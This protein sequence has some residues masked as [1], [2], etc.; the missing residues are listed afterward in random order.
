MFRDRVEAGRRLAQ[1]LLPYRT[2]SPLVLGLPRGGVPVAVE[3][4][5]ALTAPWDVLVVRKLGAPF[6]PEFAIGA[7]GEGDVVVLHPEAVSASGVSDATVQRMIAEQRREI[8]ERVR[9]FRGGR[10]MPEVAQRTV[11]VV[12]DGAATGA[13]ASA[14]VAV[15][16]S[17]GAGRIVV[18]LPVGA[19]DSVTR[20][21]TEAD[22][23]IC[24]EEPDWFH[25]VGQFYED[26]TPTTDAD[27]LALIDERPAPAGAT[28][29]SAFADEVAIP[30]A[31]GLTLPGSVT[32]PVGAVGIVAFA[33]GSGS[34][35]YSPRNQWV[36]QVLNDVGIGTLLFDLL[37]EDEAADRRNV[38]DIEFLAARLSAAKRWLTSDP[39]TSTLPIA[40]FGAST[41]AAAALVAAAQDPRA[42]RAVVS[43]GGRPDLA[44]DWLQHVQCPTL[45][46]VGGDDRQ[47]LAL[48]RTAQQQLTCMNDLVVVPGA[49]H[50]FEEPGTLQRAADLAAAWF[51]EHLTTVEAGVAACA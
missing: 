15:L 18:A 46:I 33:H 51:A 3:V 14:A 7:V 17:L 44:G 31:S 24:L 29:P 6:N 48:N 10:A 45:L 11:I 20:L 5:T 40:Y 50:L 47:V 9:R 8:E 30:V 2:T 42:V 21:R 26:F 49:T 35:R 37:T 22:D 4:A 16:R 36:A 13:T 38:F 43:R 27:V 39:R 1:A 28:V 12:D 23:V 34:S 32:V 41:G 25:A 19:R